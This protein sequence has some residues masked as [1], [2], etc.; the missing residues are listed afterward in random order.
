M[1][2]LLVAINAK[3]IHSNLAVHSLKSYVYNSCV[4]CSKVNRTGDEKNDV[5]N[6]LKEGITKGLYKDEN[7]DKNEDEIE[8]AE[9]TINHHFPELLADIYKRKPDI[10]AFSCYIW[11]WEMVERLLPELQKILPRVPI[12]L[13]GP[14]VSHRADALMQRLPMLKGIMLGEGEMT[15]KEIWNYYCDG[16]KKG[17]Q[18]DRQQE[19]RDQADRRQA[20]QGY[21]NLDR[22]DQAAEVLDKRADELSQIGGII[23]RAEEGHLIT[24]TERKLLEMDQLPFTYQNL[25]DLQ[26][27][28]IYYE[29]SR[30]CPYN[31]SYCLSAVEKSLRFKTIEKV[32]DELHKLLSAQVPQ[33]KFVD[34]TFN[35]NHHH[36]LTIWQFI[37]EHDND[38]TN[39]HF[40]IAADC[41]NAEEIHLLQTM[42]P[43]LVQLEIGVQ[44]T[45]V[46]TLRSIGRVM[47]FAKVKAVVLALQKNRNIHLHLDLIAGLPYED[48]DTFVN[49]FNE[50]Y[51]CR[52]E[53]IQLGFLKVLAGT[54]IRQQAEQ[55]KIVYG[56]S[57]PYEVLMTDWI[58]YE[59]LLCL[60]CVEEMVER[61]YNSG[62]FMNTLLV[63]EK[64][65]CSPFDLYRR[66]AD[67][68]EDKG[69]SHQSPARGYRYKI[70]LD[71][72]I[73][74]DPDNEECYRE[75]L[76]YDLYLREK[77]RN[78][79]D[80]ATD[81]NGYRE[82]IRDFYREESQKRRYLPDHGAFNATQLQ[83][84]THMEV[85]GYNVTAK[86]AEDKCHRNEQL[87][88]IL[89]DYENRDVL[90]NN[91]NVFN[92]LELRR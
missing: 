44:S 72:A 25:T 74:C 5:N 92:I 80:Y 76:T 9:Y 18:H 14:E 30:G 78:R 23:Y 57:P 24:T 1:K 75:L 79:P 3:Y 16:W 83:G 85:F 17:S 45:H 70:L 61:Y 32:A 55:H 84:M 71:F 91:A 36:A 31:C 43:G 19:N 81:I 11:N 48:Y 8:I 27:R 46:P 28:I 42:R 10:I 87:Q 33:V 20:D 53:Q 56:D 26:N 34:R 73:D 59:Q 29:S 52:P 22:Q 77:V 68:Y 66:L 2:F 41:L 47:D 15:F 64:A 49:S 51:S 39:F 6:G 86:N 21:K 50:V 58:S 54:P 37:K 82:N 40:E 88:Y 4:H 7:N 35:C 90:T 65:F 38:R 12:W 67:Y 60:H 63:L 62:Q 69:F 13:G 89:F